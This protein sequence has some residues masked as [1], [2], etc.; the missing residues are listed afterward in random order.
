MLEN[1]PQLINVSTLTIVKIILISLA[2]WFIYLIRDVLAI[3][4][5]SVILS[6]LIDPLA[7]WFGKRKIPRGLAVLTV[8]VILITVL[9]LALVLLIPPIVAQFQQLI[10][11][12]PD[13]WQ[14]ITATQIGEFAAQYDFK[15]LEESFK[16]IGASL[17]RGVYATAGGV[18][19]GITALFLILV[20][21]FYIVTQEESLK[22]TIKS[23]IPDQYLPYINQLSIKIQQKLIAWFK[24]QIILCL[25]VGFFV[26]IGLLILGVD[27]ALA[28][29]LIA[30]LTEIIPYVGPF[31][32]GATATF[33]AFGDSPLKALMVIILYVIIQQLESQLLV[34]RVMQKAVGLNPIVSIIILIIGAKLGGIVGALIAIPVASVISIFIQDF[35]EKSSNS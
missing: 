9:S 21:T 19:G 6:V 13:Y 15:N 5:I 23:F 12:L 20:L 7:N 27:Y 33:I 2:L 26:Y 28:L 31:I 29:G 35:K 24:G 3:L 17:A 25:V 1:K 32:G 18:F 30:G 16:S 11:R 4:F 34:P 8:Y 10:E 22:K 14:K